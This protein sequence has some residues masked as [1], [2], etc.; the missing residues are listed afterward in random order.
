MIDKNGVPMIKY[1]YTFGASDER[2]EEVKETGR[3]VEYEYEVNIIMHKFIIIDFNDIPTEIKYC[4]IESLYVIGRCE[5]S[6][7]FIVDNYKTLSPKYAKFNSYWDT[8]GN[9]KVGLSYYGIT[10]FLSSMLPSFF[11]ALN[12]IDPCNERECLINLCRTAIDKNLCL[13]HFGI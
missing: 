12:S 5:I 1:A 13:I 9:S 3:T 2:L 10:I 8:V 4:L 6:D 11:E 7:K